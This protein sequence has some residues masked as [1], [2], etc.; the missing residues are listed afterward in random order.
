MSGVRDIVQRFRV[1]LAPGR[2]SFLA[3][4]TPALAAWLPPRWRVSLGLTRDRLLFQR[5]DDG[6]AMAWQEGAQ[7]HELARLPADVTPADL[8]ALLGQRLADLPRWW[9]VPAE[10]ALCR[11]LSLPSAAAERLQDVVRFELDRQTPFTAAEAC[12]DAR[13]VGRREDGQLDVEL[14]VVPRPAFDAGLAA[15]GALSG[16]MAGADVAGADGL[17]RGVNLL[18]E[19]ARPAPQAPRRGLHLAL[20]AVALAATVLGMWLLLDNR[21]NAADA[22]A[23]AIEARAEQARQAATRRQQLVDLAAGITALNRAR[24]ARPTT[25]EVMDEV[26]RRLPDN[27]YLEKLSV[28]GD[29]L[30]LIGYSPEASGLVARLQGAALWRNP[31]LSGA[32]Q[33]DPR[34]RLDRF[35]LTAELVGQAQAAAPADPGRPAPGGADAAGRH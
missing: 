8:Q 31:A 9:L 25:L 5:R 13:I 10:L 3:W 14:V 28:E 20:A 26:A 29:R 6:L 35:T 15:L 7:L 21:R 16:Q 22:F 30:T 12:F 33:P 18:P 19:A 24:A 17:P 11:R 1:R 4:W 23:E 27:T 2:R 34:T 32:L